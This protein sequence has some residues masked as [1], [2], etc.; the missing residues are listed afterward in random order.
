M[1]ALIDLIEQD[2]SIND[3]VEFMVG[4]NGDAV[5]KDRLR[6]QKEYAFRHSFWEYGIL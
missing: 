4:E 5:R 6:N 3:S 1:K 2:D